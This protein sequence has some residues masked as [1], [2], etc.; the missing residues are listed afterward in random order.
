MRKNINQEN[1]VSSLPRLLEAWYLSN[2]RDLPWRA[3]KDPYQIWLSEVILQQTRVAQGLPYFLRFVEAFPTVQHLA[4]AREDEVLRLWQ[5]LGY[6][7]RARNMHAC[8]QMVVEQHQGIFPTSHDA[9]IKLK[10]VGRYTAA[11]VASFAGNEHKAVVDGNVYRV[12]SRYL[13]LWQDIS[14]SGTYQ[15]FESAFLELIPMGKSAVLNQAVMEL[16]AVI[17]LP[18]KPLCMQCPLSSSCYAFAEKKIAD[19][20]QKSKKSA[21]EEIYMHYL[22]VREKD[23]LLMKKRSSDDIWA[24]MYDFLQLNDTKALSADE[25]SKALL[26]EHLV[27]FVGMFKH[28]LTHKRLWVHVFTAETNTNNRVNPLSLNLESNF[29]NLKEIDGLPKPVTVI[30]ILDLLGISL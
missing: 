24:G 3:T 20:P 27:T 10:G 16:G 4:Q 7:N 26:P 19:L 25:V 14:K 2:H 1:E 6:Y 5:G 11:A 12:L 9:L 18:R 8:A 29:F 23:S 15:V 22:V 13:G 28:E 30:K 17:C 21:K